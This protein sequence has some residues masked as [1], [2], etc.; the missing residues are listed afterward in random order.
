MPGCLD[1]LKSQNKPGCVLLKIVVLLSGNGSNLQA[2]IDA[3]EAGELR[4][5]IVAV[6]SN[7]SNAFGLLRAT[8]ESIPTIVALDESELF[9]AI[10]MLDVDLIVLAGFMKILSPEFV[11][12]FPNKII[13]IHPSLLP[14]FKGMNTHKRVLAT[15]EK[16]HGTTV[17]IVTSE[18]DAGPI[19]AQEKIQI[20]SSDTAVT[21]E[22]KVKRIEH[23]LY[24]QV[25]NDIALG[26]ISLESRKHH[27]VEAV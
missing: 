23:S 13:N 5:R 15:A 16:E 25:I 17:H 1:E 11:A 27:H 18:L 9:S 7:E 14:K 21:L 22:E 2:M 19:L 24:P 12:N 10:D 3:I 20:E 26:R 6:I 8:A 4:A